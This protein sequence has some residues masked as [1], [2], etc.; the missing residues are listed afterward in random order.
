MKEER[1]VISHQEVTEL[2]IDLGNEDRETV[3]LGGNFSG[4]DNK[5][6]FPCSLTAGDDGQS[7]APDAPGPKT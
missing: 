6:S 2:Q 7:S 1:F 4:S 3:H 5:L